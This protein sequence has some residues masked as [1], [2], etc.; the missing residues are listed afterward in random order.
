MW[1]WLYQTTREAIAL[2]QYSQIIG[3]TL[4]GQ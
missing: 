1:Q 2:E 3:L 4:T